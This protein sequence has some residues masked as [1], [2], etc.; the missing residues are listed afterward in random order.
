MFTEKRESRN[1]LARFGSRF[2]GYNLH[3]TS[4]SF[5]AWQQQPYLDGDY[6][7]VPIDFVNVINGRSRQAE[8]TLPSGD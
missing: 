8:A 2:R 4:R 1:L 6:N 7:C 3:K 5:T